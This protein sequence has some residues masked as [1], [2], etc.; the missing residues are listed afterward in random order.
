MTRATID[1]AAQRAELRRHA[2]RLHGVLRQLEGLERRHPLNPKDVPVLNRHPLILE[3]LRAILPPPKAGFEHR[4]DT[5]LTRDLKLGRAEREQLA[6]AIE[7][8][9]QIQVARSAAATWRTLADVCDSIAAQLECE[10]A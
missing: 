7:E 2:P 4:A 10:A 3:Q 6:G 1:L 5:R 9:W 8:A